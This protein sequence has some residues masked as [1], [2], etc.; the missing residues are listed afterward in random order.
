L[1]QASAAFEMLRITVGEAGAPGTQIFTG[2]VWPPCWMF[3]RVG[4]IGS[5]KNASP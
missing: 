4:R 3:R 2:I 5:S 1:T